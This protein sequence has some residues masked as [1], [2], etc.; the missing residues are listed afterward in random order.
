MADDSNSGQFTLDLDN[1]DF[2]KK[3]LESKNLV[4]QLGDKDNMSGLLEGIGDV[5][6]AI[7]VA[8]AALYTFKTVMD[9]VF[10]GENI[11]QTNEQF[12]LLAK[13][14]GLAGDA[15][16]EGL[17][18]A[19]GGLVDE[20]ALLQAAN[21]AMVEMGGNAAQ[22]P[23]LMDLARKSTAV[24]GGDLLTNF[25]EMSL[26]IANGNQRMLAHKGIVVDVQLAYRQYAESIGILPDQLSKTE[27][28]YVLLNAALEKGDKAFAGADLN[29]KQTTNAVTELK[30]ALKELWDDMA[31]NITK[32]LGPAMTQM[33]NMFTK[34]IKWVGG[35]DKKAGASHET[36]GPEAPAGGVAKKPEL[37]PEEDKKRQD[38]LLK[39]SID[40]YKKES[41]LTNEYYTLQQNLADTDE[42]A[43]EAFHQREAALLEEAY[44]KKQQIALEESQGKLNP[45]QAADMKIQVEQNTQLKLQEMEMQTL[46]VRERAQD[47]FLKKSTNTWDG[48]ARAAKAG[49]AKAQLE[50][51]DFAKTGT[52]VVGAFG[53]NATNSLVA[54]GEGSQ[55]AGD[56]M[57]GFL[58]GALADIAQAMGAVKILAYPNFPEMAAGAA[59]LVLSGVLRGMAKGASSGISTPSS[60]GSSSSS[61]AGDYGSQSIAAANA[62]VNPPTAAAA[63]TTQQ[64]VNVYGSIFDSDQ[65]ATRIVTM[66]RNAGDQTDYKLNFIQGSV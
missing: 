15:L 28:E 52:M 20:N 27:K 34:F 25:N 12:E 13:N 37:T 45:Q 14:M 55:T 53:K 57:R 43:M 40:R 3:I 58:F 51:Q 24:F 33:T 50:M 9:L 61:G 19:S 7:G 32:N 65:T 17:L 18:K 54:L 38:D 59:L 60:S 16:K 11:K 1:A 4:M 44:M 26:A 47:Q 8:A 49:G 48:I 30:V 62:S 42:K 2:V 10:E 64:T 29:I 39:N 46:Q 36:V 31:S 66:M 6:P 56:A 41:A 23:Q 5:A 22:I 21:K 63:K 35:H